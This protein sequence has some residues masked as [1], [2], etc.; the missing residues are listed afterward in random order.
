[1]VVF[2][3]N[4]V[5]VC[6]GMLVL[7]VKKCKVLRCKNI[8]TMLVVSAAFREGPHSSVSWEAWAVIEFEASPTRWLALTRQR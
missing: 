1:M 3:H 8:K 2:C 6:L 4:S 5:H 7:S